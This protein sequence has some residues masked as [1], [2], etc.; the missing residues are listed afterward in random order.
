MEDTLT[1]TPVHLFSSISITAMFAFVCKFLGGEEGCM[2]MNE[3][4][5]K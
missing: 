5:E 1:N 2:H 4:Q 3:R